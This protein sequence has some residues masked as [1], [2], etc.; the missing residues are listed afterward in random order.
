MT[1]VALTMD[2]RVCVCVNTEPCR[3]NNVVWYVQVWILVKSCKLIL[4][5]ASYSSTTRHLSDWINLGTKW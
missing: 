2:T 1:I 3:W 5:A 4:H